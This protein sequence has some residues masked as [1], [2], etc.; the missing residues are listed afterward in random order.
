MSQ[1]QKRLRKFSKILGFYKFSRFG[2]A[3]YSR[4]EALVARLY[5]NFCGSLRDFLA[6]GP[7]SHKKHL[8]N[9]SKFLSQRCL[10]A[11]FGDLFATW[12]SRKKRMF[13]ALRTVFKTFQFSLEHFLL[14][15]VL[16]VHLSHKLTMFL[17]K[18]T[19]VLHLFYFNLQEKVWVFYFWL[20]ISCLKVQIVCKTPWTFRPSNYKLPIQAYY[21][22]MYVQ[23]MNIS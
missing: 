21:Q 11:W 12:F 18:A 9:F 7:S 22:T 6:S 17:L 23:N 15:I 1:S 14:F 5:R 10:V 16:F 4:V 13:C 3:T 19:I 20:S 2:L 8:D